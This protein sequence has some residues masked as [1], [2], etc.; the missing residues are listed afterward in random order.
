MDDEYTIN[1]T[2]VDAKGM[3]DEKIMLKELIA[4]WNKAWAFKA[5]AA[6]SATELVSSMAVLPSFTD[7]S[8]LTAETDMK[9]AIEM[10]KCTGQ[11]EALGNVLV[12]M[13]VD[14]EEVVELGTRCSEDSITLWRTL[15]KSRITQLKAFWC[16]LHD[17]WDRKEYRS[18]P[19]LYP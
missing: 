19:H 15:L 18:V 7:E 2:R 13:R 12:E 10:A 4:K 11:M 8:A 16:H 5:F 6:K 1:A 17:M 9:K 14:R 3:S